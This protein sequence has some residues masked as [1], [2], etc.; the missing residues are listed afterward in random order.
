[1]YIISRS[2]QRN[3]PEKLNQF[4]ASKIW[5]ESSKVQILEKANPNLTS[6][7]PDVLIGNFLCVGGRGFIKLCVFEEKYIL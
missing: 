2:Y 7:I 3:V 4:A 5:I 1:M 6:L